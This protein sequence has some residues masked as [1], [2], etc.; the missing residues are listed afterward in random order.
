MVRTPVTLITG[1]LGAGKSTLINRILAQF[2]EQRFGIVVNEF[3]EVQ[4]E[5]AVI[6][7]G[8]DEV[9]ELSGGCMCCVT[10]RDLGRALKRLLAHRSQLDRV[11]LE[12]S[13][14][15]DPL[16]VI[17]TLSKRGLASQAYLDSVITVVD[18][19]RFADYRSR[20]EVVEAQ[21]QHADIVLLSKSAYAEHGRKEAT[22]AAVRELAPQALLADMDDRLPLVT[23]FA[24]HGYEGRHRDE[25]AL[26]SD[27]VLR[28]AELNSL[29]FECE[30]PL[31]REALGAV[32]N[33]LPTGLIRAKGY[34][35]LD[36]RDGH[37]HKMVLQVVGRRRSLEA[38]RWQRNEPRKTAL[39]FLGHEIDADALRTRLEACALE[40]AG[41][42]TTMRVTPQ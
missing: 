21:V 37:K 30:S 14:A 7:A 24:G 16:P 17:Q 2:S 26:E 31:E 34:V 6:D 8:I 39:L 9:V 42:D 4:L 41:G 33:D 27:G 1:F 22:H 5:S 11:L 32:L 15:S 13:G 36:G 12:A 19:E 18:L 20:Y 28:H 38:V 3:G 29:L 25:L 40:S 23:L 35:Y 10:R